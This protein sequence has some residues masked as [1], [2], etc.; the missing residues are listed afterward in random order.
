MQ[1]G[2]FTPG[3]PGSS[4]GP[5]DQNNGGVMPPSQQPITRPPVEIF[6]R[7]PGYGFAGLDVSTAIGN[8]T[9]TNFELRFPRTLLGLLDWQRTYNS[10]SG[11]IGA[12]GPGWTTSFSASL[13]VTPAQGGLL[14]H[15][16][17]SVTFHN[18]DGRILAF[19]PD[20]SGGYA[21]TQDL[22]ATLAR[23]ADGTFALAYNSGEIWSFD[24]TGRLTGRSLEGQQVT[25]SYDSQDLLEAAAHSSG[26]SLAFS[27]DDNR[28]LTSVTADDGRAVSFA[29]GQGTVTDALL[30]AVTIPGGGTY[31]LD[32]AG[33]GQ[34]SQVS[35][36]TDPDGNLI[37]ANTYDPAT[38]AV[39]G[40]EFGSGGGAAFRY[41]AATAVTTVTAAP[42]G[43]Q[44]TYS[45]D[46]N[47]RLVRLA[48]PDGSQATFGYDDSGFLA[49]ATTPGGTQLAQTHDP[50]GHLLTSDFGGSLTTWSRDALGRVS[51]V[52]QPSGGVTSYAYDGASHI[53]AQVTDADGG[54]T[55]IGSSGGLV[56]SRANPDGNTTTY[57][58]DA[59]SNLTQISR[60]GGGV[61]SL[62]HDAAGNAIGV[63]T[64][65]G[66]THQWAY[67]SNG[68]V[69]QY[70][71]PGGAV[72]QFVYSPAGLL[73]QQSG[74]GTTAATYGYGA[75]GNLTSTT[76][77]L[78]NQTTFGYDQ[79]GNLASVTNPVGGVTQYG[80]NDLGQLASVTD[81][82]ETV[83]QFGYDADGNNISQTGPSG[84]VT[85]TYDARGNNTSVTSAAGATIRYGYDAGDRLTSM[86]D[87]RGGTWQIGYDAIGNVTSVYDPSGAGAQ[88]SWSGTGQPA[89]ATDPLGRQQ[90]CTY[91]ADG[92]LTEVTDAQGGVTRYA[93]DQD[94]RRI[95]VTTPAGLVTR[96]TYDSSGRVVA[97]TDPRGWITRT[98]YDA[99]GRRIALITPSGSVTRYAYDAAGQLTE[100]TDGNGA[101]TRYGYDAAGRLVAITD[102]KG[103]VTRYGYDNN[104]N[105][106]SE[107]D[108]LGRT[109]QR[110]Y[111]SAGNLITITDPSGHQQHLSYDSDGQLTQWT[112][113]DAFPVSFGYDG[114]GHR[115]TMTDATGTTRYTYDAVGNLT[116][117]T[118]PDGSTLA[119]AYDAAGQ[120]ISLSY[121]SGLTVGYGYDLNGRLITLTDS[122][123]GAAVYALN[124]DGL[125]LTEQLPG[126]HARR[127]RYEGGLLERFAIITDGRE[128][129]WTALTRDPDG[130]ISS[131]RDG[132]GVREFRYDGAG[133]LV[134]AGRQ[135]DELHLT[136]DLAG[137]RVRARHRDIDT[138]YSYDAASQLTHLESRGRRAEFRYDSSGRLTAEIDGD[139]RRVIRYNGFGWPVEVSWNTGAARDIATTTFNGD[140]LADLVV[141][142]SNGQERGERSASFWY[143]WS[144]GDQI[145]QVLT[146]QTA[147]RL[148]D[149]ERGGELDTDFSY[150]YGRTF[151]SSPHASAVFRHDAYASAIRTR[152]T[153]AWTQAREYD[154]FGDPVRTGQEQAG[155]ERLFP[156]LPRFGYRG[157]LALGSLIDL[158]ARVYDSVLGRFTSRDPVL[159]SSP[160]PGQ[161]ANPYLYAGNDPLNFTDPLGTLLVAPT[162]G[163]AVTSKLP[164]APQASNH[165]AVLTSAVSSQALSVGGDRSSVHNVCT[166]AGGLVLAAQLA[167]QRG[168]PASVQFEMKIPQAAKRNMP[169]LPTPSTSVSKRNYGKADLAITYTT[170]GG[171]AGGI[172]SNIYIWETKSVLN[173]AVLMARATLANEE[174]TWYSDVFNLRAQFLSQNAT[175]QPGPPMDIPAEV[176]LPPGFPGATSQFY[177]VFSRPPGLFG[178]IL[179]KSS[180]FRIPPGVPVYQYQPATETLRQ[181]RGPQPTPVGL[182]AQRLVLGAALA[183]GLLG[184]GGAAAYQ[185]ASGIAEI[186]EE[187]LEALGEGVL[188]G[189]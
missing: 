67:D 170:A 98:E 134:Y 144:I 22:K 61:V 26:R 38:S 126:R 4:P 112:A 160:S 60:P 108:P 159:S 124:P 57:G 92:R 66:E 163:G 77:A 179:Y 2:A 52:T 75:L 71:S 122:R 78:G 156:E 139:R 104:G 132:G 128:E 64:P 96:Y 27:Y 168:I 118:G 15:T 25:L 152:E 109:A 12:L 53:P 137:N 44:F 138:H 41:D 85:A 16:A 84:T 87:P 154:A 80:Y 39:T 105:L 175:A 5:T 151:A 42:S 47:G 184:V 91:D 143:R 34:A 148:D 188:E 185:V 62:S 11:A 18:E 43:A 35:R 173:G 150:G 30:Q 164:P 165:T 74:P 149:A 32:Y 162:G 46:T 76:D 19:A 6:G 51:E 169:N 8:F 23:N 136:Y 58:Y 37:V 147:P 65:S 174:A 99:A 100:Q 3:D 10:H 155:R 140:G 72:S 81:P 14:H 129:A 83:T 107:T 111:D 131:Q 86:T 115:T 110:A 17:A 116:G 40:Q 177:E 28:R 36:I 113:D 55:R 7:Y 145:P 54:V 48:S 133:Q 69:S 176:W 49:A 82:N 178:T 88:L 31:Q 166:V 59:R 9:Q 90:T 153:E 79:L 158:R 102:P 157:E 94:G 70:T 142:T 29:Y 167:A 103:E 21:R 63:S 125:L 93:H 68:Q 95:S 114:A 171:L 141:L 73:L 106:T 119:A 121:P 33:T 182:G 183:T 181:V 89:T 1:P 45:A 123:A 127:Y 13:V 50:D 20:A 187:I 24:T 56:T 120:Q 97:T 117:I 146:Q 189:A 186:I 180:T 130:R 101:V 172:Y 135:G 161:D